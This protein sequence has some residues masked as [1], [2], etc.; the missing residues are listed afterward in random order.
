[1]IMHVIQFPQ[2]HAAKFFAQGS[3]NR[4]EQPMRWSGEDDITVSSHE[5]NE[6]GGV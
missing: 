3:D 2:S 4:G 1:M 6:A 5:F